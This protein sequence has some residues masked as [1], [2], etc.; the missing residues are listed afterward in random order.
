VANKVIALAQQQ[1]QQTKKREL[2]EDD[3]LYQGFP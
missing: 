2:R 3:A 1:Q